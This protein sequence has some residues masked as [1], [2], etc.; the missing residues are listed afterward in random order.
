MKIL[1]VMPHYYYAQSEG[2]RFRSLRPSALEPRTR[3]LE[4][5]VGR[6]QLYF[7]G[8]AFGAIHDKKS[9]IPIEGVD[10]IDLRIVTVKDRHLLTHAR[11]PAESFTHVQV[12]ID[13]LTLG[14]HAHTILQENAGKYDYYVYLEDDILIEDPDL[15]LKIGYLNRAAT[16]A[17]ITNAL[18]QPQR[19]ESALGLGAREK[20]LYNAIVMDYQTE[21]R[22]SERV[23]AAEYL[24]RRV[25]FEVTTLPHAGCFFLNEQQLNTL[26][27]KENFGHLDR[28]WVTPL[29]TAATYAIGMNF[30]VYKPV[31]SDYLFLAV[32]HGCE[33]ISDKLESGHLRIEN[34]R[35]VGWLNK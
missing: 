30:K 16:Q 31:L 35:P 13:P 11:I 4:E 2:A 15:F 18:F 14:F 7:G 25:H 22:A 1:V 28:M 8:K 27:G 20:Q 32:R 9:F 6:L 24:G 10:Q 3:M 5:V 33:V 29:D 12:D 26:V 34:G 21:L 23:L 17:G 19:Y